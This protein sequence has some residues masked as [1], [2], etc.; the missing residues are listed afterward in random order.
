VFTFTKTVHTLSD[1]FG[2]CAFKT[3][4][5]ERADADLTDYKF[6]VIIPSV[7][8]WLFYHFVY[9]HVLLSVV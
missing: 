5:T 9:Y 7:I 1:Y 4:S 8:L 2:M 3:T 6:T